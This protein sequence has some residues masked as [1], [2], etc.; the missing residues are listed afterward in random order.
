MLEKEDPQEKYGKLQ[1]CSDNLLK[2]A[3]HG[4]LVPTTTNIGRKLLKEEK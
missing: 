3:M 4:R 2:E 1:S